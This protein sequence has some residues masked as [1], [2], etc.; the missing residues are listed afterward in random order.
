MIIIS[1]FLVVVCLFLYYVT[2]KMKELLNQKGKELYVKHWERR[3]SNDEWKNNSL[4]T[5][6][7]IEH[8]VYSEMSQNEE[9]LELYFAS[10][11]A[12]K[13][14]NWATF[15]LFLTTASTFFV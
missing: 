15:L 8:L 14:L 4:G 1:L 2:E 6:K 10:K 11:Q 12:E 5:D 7:H 13:H 3:Y 9:C